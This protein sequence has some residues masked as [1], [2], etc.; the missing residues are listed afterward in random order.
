VGHSGKSAVKDGYDGG[1]SSNTMIVMITANTPS[2][3]A[4]SRSGVGLLLGMP[5]SLQTHVGSNHESLRGLIESIRA[6][7]TTAEKSFAGR[8][9]V[10]RPIPWLA[11]VTI[12]TDPCIFDC[13]IAGHWLFLVMS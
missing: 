7:G 4:P 5:P 11:P 3:N 8:I 1:F 10:A 9:A 2:E 13:P 12:A 6:A